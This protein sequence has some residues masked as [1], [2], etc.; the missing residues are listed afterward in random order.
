MVERFETLHRVRQSKP[1][2][3]EER[4]G[5]FG[6]RCCDES[7]D[8]SSFEFIGWLWVAACERDALGTLRDGADIGSFQFSVCCLFLGQAQETV[9]MEGMVPAVLEEP[10]VFF[11]GDRPSSSKPSP[12]E[13]PFRA[14]VEELVLMH[15]K[16]LRTLQGQL[17]T[18]LAEK[19]GR[20]DSK[21]P[22]LPSQDGADPVVGFIS[23]GPPRRRNDG[24][25]IRGSFEG[26]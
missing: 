23:S 13:D 7:R 9:I 1:T 8:E 2:T 12:L 4:T 26:S 14:L 25:W 19:V 15:K 17:D 16:D 24:L 21:Q 22:S 18:L 10:Q 11:D 20:V 3:P 5:C 6:K